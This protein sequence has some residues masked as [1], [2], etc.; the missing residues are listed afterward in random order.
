MSTGAGAR[1]RSL[2][3]MLEITINP[4]FQRSYELEIAAM[5]RTFAF[6]VDPWFNFGDPRLLLALIFLVVGFAR[7][8]PRKS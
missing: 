8:A 1:Y 5:K 3:D 4:E 2:R 7:S 6:P